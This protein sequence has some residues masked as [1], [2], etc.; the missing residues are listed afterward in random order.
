MFE[1][2]LLAWH[3][4]PDL[5]AVELLSFLDGLQSYWLRDPDIDFLAQWEFFADRFFATLNQ[6]LSAALRW[7]KTTSMQG[8]RDLGAAAS[9]NRA[10]AP[11]GRQTSAAHCAGPGA[12]APIA[13]RGVRRMR[14]LARPDTAAPAASASAGQVSDPRP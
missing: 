13:S 14:L 12:A 6:R 10:G 1:R 5:A 4:R 8:R 3:R 2:Y 7:P 11:V 9:G